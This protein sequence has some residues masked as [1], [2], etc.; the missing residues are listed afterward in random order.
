MTTEIWKPIEGYEDRYAVSNMGQVMNIKSRRILKLK[1]ERNGYVRAHLSKNNKPKSV[2]VHRLVALAFVPNPNGYPTVN[3]I[4]EDKQNNSASNLEWTTM[5]YQNTYGV[6]A[7][8]RNRA[9]ERA[10]YQYTMDGEFI[11]RFDSVK[12]AAVALGLNPSNIHSVCKGI[13]R[14]K[15]TGGFKFKY[16]TDVI[17]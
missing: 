4:D 11:A 2:S 13:K 1:T 10:V 6:G 9:K 12:K 3:H 5:S 7:V 8:N 15:S 14:Y 16:E 17:N